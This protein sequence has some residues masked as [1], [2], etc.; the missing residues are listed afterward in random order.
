MN[1][2]KACVDA[3]SQQD[4]HKTKYWFGIFDSLLNECVKVQMVTNNRRHLDDD[5]RYGHNEQITQ[6]IANYWLAATNTT[7]ETV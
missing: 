6:H 2:Q 3:H 7:T 4:L 1:I 5:F